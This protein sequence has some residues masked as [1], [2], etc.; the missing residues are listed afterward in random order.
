[1]ILTDGDNIHI[2]LYD[3]IISLTTHTTHLAANRKDP[4][5]RSLL[6][7]ADSSFRSSSLSLVS[8][9]SGMKARL[10]RPDKRPNGVEPGIIRDWDEEG[11]PTC[12]GV[13]TG[14]VT[15]R[16]ASSTLRTYAL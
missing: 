14:T 4:D 6:S 3:L 2:N 9:S 8:L 7:D 13:G 1:M 12:V 11:Y 16:N 10:I 5:P 15:P